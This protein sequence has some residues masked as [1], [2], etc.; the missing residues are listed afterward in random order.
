MS[1]TFVQSTP[2]WPI[3]VSVA[4]CPLASLWRVFPSAVTYVVL[5]ATFVDVRFPE[6][7]GGN[8]R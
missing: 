6:F 2:G 1:F 4:P 3:L 8:S 7:G 5:S